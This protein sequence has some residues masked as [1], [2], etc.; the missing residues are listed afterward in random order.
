MMRCMLPAILMAAIGLLASGCCKSLQCAA[1]RTAQRQL[2]CQAVELTEVTEQLRLDGRDL[3]ADRRVQQAKGC[4][5]KLNLECGLI[6]SGVIH[7][8]S[9]LTH[10]PTSEVPPEFADPQW[11]CWELPDRPREVEAD[12]P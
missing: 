3:P 11:R 1:Q 12:E 9:E 2:G 10:Q 8:E 6:T 4:G 5:R 7:R